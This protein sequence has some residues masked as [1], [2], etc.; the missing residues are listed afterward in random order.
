MSGNPPSHKHKWKPSDA[1]S[2][3]VTDTKI[4]RQSS[5]YKWQ[6]GMRGREGEHGGLLGS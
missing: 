2:T 4:K 1:L 3:V 6:F 5:L